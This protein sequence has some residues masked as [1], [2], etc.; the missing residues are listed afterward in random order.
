[1]R[2]G[3]S[4][5]VIG[6]M[7][8]CLALV[9]GLKQHGQGAASPDAGG[10]GPLILD[11]VHF[12]PGEPR[13]ETR[14]ADPKVTKELGCNGKVY[15]LFDA[16]TLAVNWDSVDPDILP[17]DSPDRK[18]VDETAARIR[19]EQAACKS[20]GLEA[21]AMSDEI[22][23]P[24]RLIDKF[25]MQ[26]TFGDV[27][28][29]KT[30][31][32]LRLVIGLAFD[33]FPNLDGLVVRIGETYLQDAPFHVGAVKSPKNADTTIIPL[34]NILRDEICVKRNK[35]LIFRT[36]DSFD[37][38]LKAY[39]KI[40]DA[41]EPHPKLAFSVKFCEGDFRRGNP[42]SK[43][44]GQGRQ[45]QVIEVQ[46]AREYEGK[47]AYPNYIASGVIDGFEENRL[48]MPA[49]KLKS[50]GEFARTSP[51]FAGIWIWSRGGGWQGPYIKNEL[52]CDL[53]AWVMAQWANDVKQSEESVFDRY[54]T[55]KLGIKGEDIARFRK[56]ALLSA[57]A[58][59]RGQAST[60]SDISP[61]WTR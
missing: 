26:K 12:N 23:L 19:A 5:R 47:G 41:V 22:V 43:I 8:I 34:I 56:L 57:D 1:M 37:V 33:Q 11:M 7:V 44:I 38:N 4:E 30:E 42:F 15:F 29:P 45:P 60:M 28:D 39:L 21:Y 54:A 31:K 53:N 9:C 3:T 49:D 18:W 46:C 52:W 6:T 27:R 16:P 35:R 55:E 20:Q 50:I 13:Y 61:W 2:V 58:V 59:V 24:K 40:C 10:H 14:F 17:K 51:L 48:Q 32:Y 25:G 36:W